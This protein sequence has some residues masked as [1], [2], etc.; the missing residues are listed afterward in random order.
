MFWKR[1]TVTCAYQIEC[2]R[3][4]NKLEDWKKNINYENNPSTIQYYSM[5]DSQWPVLPS[6]AIYSK[7]TVIVCFYVHY[8]WFFTC[9]TCQPM[10]QRKSAF[11]IWFCYFSLKQCL[12]VNTQH[13]SR[14]QL[15]VLFAKWWKML[16]D[17]CNLE[18]EWTWN[19]C[20][21]MM[22]MKKV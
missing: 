5:G 12:L 4:K 6:Q 7:P 19:W 13:R 9:F 20:R 15:W 14:G 16:E 11:N 22:M 10:E 2:F 18:R 8:L 3:E 17:S 21:V 1:I